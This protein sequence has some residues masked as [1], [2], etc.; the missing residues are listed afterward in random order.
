MWITAH[1]TKTTFIYGWREY[2][3]GKGSKKTTVHKMIM[4]GERIWSI[5]KNINARPRLK[6]R[7]CVRFLKGL[8]GRVQQRFKAQLQ[9]IQIGVIYR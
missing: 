1:I 4:Y 8:E 7:E 6:T 3:N 2:S 9:K 5:Y